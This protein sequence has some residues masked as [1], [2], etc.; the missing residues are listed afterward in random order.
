MLTFFFLTLFCSTA[1]AEEHLVR[2]SPLAGTWYPADKQQLERN[3]TTYIAEATPLQLKGR[4]LGLISPHAGIEWSGKAAAFSYKVIKGKKIRR[5]LLL[6][7]SHYMAF[8]GIA[9]SGVDFY[10]TPLGRVKVDREISD[11]LAQH[12]LFQGP[13]SA[14]LREHSLE[15]QL[16]FLQ[17]VLENFSLVPLVVG[18]IA[19]KDYT[20][21]AKALLPYLD[22][23]TIVVASSD[24]TH[25]GRRFG[26]FPFKENIGRNLRKLDGDA[27]EKI[28]QKDFQGYLTY[29][30]ETGITICGA[31]PIGILLRMMPASASGTL[32]HYYT[33]GDL[34]QDFSSSVSYA[35]I[36][37][38]T[39]K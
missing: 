27:I 24:F 23:S 34:T 33:S 13:N 2:K 20:E 11:A 7:P 39:E 9:T 4:I 38:T 25:F 12:S 26:Y 31:R 21:A 1:G 6:G 18:A 15:M 3:I 10:E 28:V 30:T 32:L 5:V 22:G 16:P 37:F 17:V 8:Q 14:E 36:A 19:E 29:L 35:S